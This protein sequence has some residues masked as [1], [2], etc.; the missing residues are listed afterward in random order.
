MHMHRVA[1]IADN[2][3]RAQAAGFLFVGV[4]PFAVQ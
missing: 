2:P 1:E 4:S 3:F